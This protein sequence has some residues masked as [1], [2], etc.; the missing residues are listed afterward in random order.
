MSAEQIFTNA[1]VVLADEVLHG[2]VVVKDGV[3]TDISAGNITHP[4]AVN[5]EGNYLIPGLVELH[6]DNLEK[7]MM[8]RP[9]VSWPTTS[10]MISHDNQIASA[11]ITTVFDAISIGDIHPKSVRLDSLTPMIE[12][13]NYSQKHGLTRSEH[14]LHLRCEVAHPE[15]WGIFSENVGNEHV[16][17]VSLMDHTPGQRQFEEISHYRVYYRQKY[18]LTLDEMAAFEV[19]QIANA[20]RYSQKYRLDIADYCR[21]HQIVMASHDDATED[22]VAESATLGMKIAEFPTTVEAAIHSTRRDLSVLM[23]AP[24]IVRGGSHSGNVAASALA[25]QDLLHILSSD[26]YPGS[27]IQA[28]FIL[29]QEE[30]GFDLPKAIRCVSKNPA[31]AVNL[32]DRGEIALGKKADLLQVSLHGN[33]PLIQSVWKSGKRVI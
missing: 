15:T 10:A 13:L 33:Q 14:K 1:N 2:T 17:L 25:K 30:I 11:G 28:A 32:R 19:Q 5:F 22:H 16:G 9:T 23:G 31:E 7:H 29:T 26:Y 12:A 18:G 4:S 24:N 21:N 6:T 20:K 3:I 27:L 8:P